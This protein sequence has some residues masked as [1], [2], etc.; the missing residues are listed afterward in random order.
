MGGNYCKRTENKTTNFNV[1]LIL[2]KLLKHHFYPSRQE[3]VS[4]SKS[5]NYSIIT[6]GRIQTYLGKSKIS[7]ILCGQTLIFSFCANSATLYVLMFVMLFL[8]KRNGQDTT[9][10]CSSVFV[11]LKLRLVCTYTYIYIIRAS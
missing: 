2:V 6:V 4:L 3:L 1:F 11:G 8:K 7:G 10:N 5:I 9:V